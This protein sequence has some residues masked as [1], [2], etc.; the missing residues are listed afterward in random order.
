MNARHVAI[1]CST[2]LLALG[3]SCGSSDKKSNTPPDRPKNTGA[4]CVTADDCYKQNIDRTT[5]LGT[6][7]C[8]DRVRD[9][10]CTH[11]CTAD[12]DCCAVTG[13]CP[14]G[15]DEVCAP[16]ENTGVTRCFV[17]CEDSVLT[18]GDSGVVDA[19]E[20]CQR[21]ASPEFICRAS[22][23]GNPRK[24]CVPGDCGVG[25]DCA[26]DADCP[27]GTLCVTDFQGGYCTVRDCTATSCPAGSVCV[28][29]A[30]GPYCAVTCTAAS[31]CSFCRTTNATACTAGVTL[32]DAT[33]ASVCLPAPK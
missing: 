11:Q 19:N 4:A 20:F 32:V 22:G 2:L 27:T 5:I 33:T 30:A 9:G 10:Y 21:M 1:A 7:E 3:V 31:D 24:V 12:T 26:V 17:S 8:L 13:E 14:E 29:G 16:F 23:G 15:L 6:I 28:A 25:A 18:P